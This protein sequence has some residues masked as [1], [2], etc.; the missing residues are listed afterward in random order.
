MCP[1]SKPPG[2]SSSV[3]FVRIEC[4]GE[5]IGMMPPLF[6]P[7]LRKYEYESM[8][9]ILVCATVAAIKVGTC[10]LG[11][12]VSIALS[13][14]SQHNSSLTTLR[15]YSPPTRDRIGYAPNAPYEPVAA[16]PISIPS[17]GALFHLCAQPIRVPSQGVPPSQRRAAAAIVPKSPFQPARPDFKTLMRKRAASAYACRANP[18]PPPAPGATNYH[19]AFAV[20]P[21]SRWPQMAHMAV[22]CACS[23]RVDRSVDDYVREIGGI[24]GRLVSTPSYSTRAL[25]PWYTA[26]VGDGHTG[27]PVRASL[28]GLATALAPVA[29][30]Y[31]DREKASD[32]RSCPLLS[33]KWDKNPNRRLMST[34]TSHDT[35]WTGFAD[36]LIGSSSPEPACL[37]F[38]AL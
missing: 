32:P 36:K 17:H 22:T 14:S 24:E 15:K 26:P 1:S 25:A 30:V 2:P 12:L 7:A 21:A 6:V 5:A 11:Q 38:R 29:G 35:E 9:L 34:R 27:S 20:Y 23:I 33:S 19:R 18:W 37:H 10:F 3:L 13:I 28:F 31:R 8:Y 16:A 4:A